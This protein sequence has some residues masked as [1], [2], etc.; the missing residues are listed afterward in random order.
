MLESGG[1]QAGGATSDFDG[2]YTI[3]PVSPG[4]YTLKATFVGYGDISVKDVSISGDKTTYYE[5]KMSQ[6][7]GIDL[8][9]VEVIFYEDLIDKDNMTTGQ[10]LTREDIERLPVRSVA[11]LT[12]IS[13]GVVNGQIRGSRNGATQTFID[14]IKVI[15]SI[16]LPRSAIGEMNVITGGV[17]AQY[18]D[19]TVESEVS[20]PED[21]LQHLLQH[22]N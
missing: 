4:K 11:E 13:V 9:P 18:G 14:G 19:L 21:L 1:I 20:L 12:T 2:N 15:G 6:G 10:R 7:E 17:P 5:I 3:K 8:G 16:N 22:L